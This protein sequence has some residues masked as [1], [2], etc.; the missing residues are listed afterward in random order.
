ML[1][2]LEDLLTRHPSARGHELII[3]KLDPDACAEINGTDFLQIMLNLTINALQS[4][5]MPHRV[6]VKARRMETPVDITTIAD[7]ATERVIN[8]ST[9][10]N[11]APL[12]AISVANTGPGISPFVLSR[13]FEEKFTTKSADRGTGLGLSIVRRLLTEAKGAIHL[14]TDPDEGSTF[15]VYLQIAE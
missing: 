3:H 12:L 1:A 11:R 15:T 10:L 8:R 14:Q 7:S 13:M 9:F 5:D 6:E 4:T 2:D